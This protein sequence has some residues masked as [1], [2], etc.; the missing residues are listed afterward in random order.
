MTSNWKKGIRYLGGTQD[1][2]LR[3]IQALA[4]L[5][6][7]QVGELRNE[8]GK[9]GLRPQH[10]KGLA[11]T[12]GARF[13]VAQDL[14]LNLNVGFLIPEANYGCAIRFSNAGAWVVADKEKDLRGCAL[15]LSLAD[16]FIQPLQTR[17]S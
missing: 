6:T 8:T 3:E 10:A 13:V 16:G 7:A 2:E 15:K 4:K 11:V 5:V 14:P 12:R 1:A 17:C 9:T